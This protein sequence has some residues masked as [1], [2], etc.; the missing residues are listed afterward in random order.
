[1]CIAYCCKCLSLFNINLLLFIVFPKIEIL[2]I[3]HF[4]VNA[5]LPTLKERN[6][7]DIDQNLIS[8]QFESWNEFLDYITVTVLFCFH[9]LPMPKFSSKSMFLYTNMSQA[10]NVTKVCFYIQICHK[11]KMSQAIK[12]IFV[13]FCVNFLIT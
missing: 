8:Q 3:F 4:L 11:P 6:G 5:N 2:I 1:M 13:R 9:C 12:I 7:M 10:K